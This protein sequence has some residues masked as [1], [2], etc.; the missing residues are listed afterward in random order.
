MVRMQCQPS[1]KD[2]EHPFEDIKDVQIYLVGA[3]GPVKLYQ[4]ENCEL[5][6]TGVRVARFRF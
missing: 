4:A 2:E 1:D 3:S 6:I 5:F